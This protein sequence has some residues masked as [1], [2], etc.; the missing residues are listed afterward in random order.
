MRLKLWMRELDQ[1]GVGADD[2]LA[3]EATQPR[4]LDADLLHCAALI[5]E[6]ND[7]ADLEGT[8]EH[9][10]ERGE[11]IAEHAL[12]CERDSDAAD[13]ETCD[14]RRHVETEILEDQQKRERPNADAH[15]HL[16]DRDRVAHGRLGLTRRELPDQQRRDD[17]VGPKRELDEQRNDEGREQH[18]LDGWRKLEQRCAGID[19]SD[20]EEQRRGPLDEVA[21]HGGPAEVVP[22]T[23]LGQPAQ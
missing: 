22:R 4:G 11:E 15:Q 19:R 14:E 5:A 13:A 2:L 10:G 6:H 1:V 23:R 9:D 18:L 21:E 7:V 20:D 8:V 16:D 17:A 3:R 12:R